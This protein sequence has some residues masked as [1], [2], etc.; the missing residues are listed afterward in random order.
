[1]QTP[2]SKN[3]TVRNWNTATKLLELTR[4]NGNEKTVYNETDN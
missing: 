1:M 3:F 4:N 2:V